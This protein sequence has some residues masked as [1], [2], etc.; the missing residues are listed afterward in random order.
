MLNWILKDPRLNSKEA[1][2]IV[3]LP[4]NTKPPYLFDYL[5]IPLSFNF[6]TGYFFKKKTSLSFYKQ[7][8]SFMCHGNLV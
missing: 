4:P 6:N 1:F 3:L 7:T 2:S 8:M 5:G